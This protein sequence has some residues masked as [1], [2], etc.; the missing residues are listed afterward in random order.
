MRIEIYAV[1]MDL[2]Q[3]IHVSVAGGE[4]SIGRSFR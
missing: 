1:K 4:R 2:T 3:N